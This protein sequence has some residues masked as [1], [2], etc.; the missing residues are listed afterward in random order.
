MEQGD[1]RG[2]PVQP[3]GVGDH[4]PAELDHE[5][6]VAVLFDVRQSLF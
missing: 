1:L 5:D 2:Q 4:L 6:L 3:F